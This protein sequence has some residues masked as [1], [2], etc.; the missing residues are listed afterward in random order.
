MK[1]SSEIP[2]LPLCLV[3]QARAAKSLLIRNLAACGVGRMLLHACC[4]I[5]NPRHRRWH[6]KGITR[7]LEL[8]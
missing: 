1:T 4:A 2:P 7:E 3:I 8:L 5:Q 6:L